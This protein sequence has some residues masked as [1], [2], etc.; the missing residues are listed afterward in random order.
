MDSSGLVM[1]MSSSAKD[2]ARG[3]LSAAGQYDLSG[4]RRTIT[5]SRSIIPC[6]STEPV[7]HTCN[8]TGG[9]EPHRYRLLMCDH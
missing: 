7:P 1:E 4:S 6:L 8:A 3:L 9:S 5:C 2:M